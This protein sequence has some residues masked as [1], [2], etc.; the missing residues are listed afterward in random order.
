[1]TTDES[2]TTG[3]DSGEDRLRVEAEPTKEFFVSMLVRDIELLDA[4]IDLLDNSIDGAR[5]L[6]G[7]GALDDLFV[8]V[9]VDEA[10]FSI[11]DNC[12]GIEAEVARRY[13]FRFGR[14]EQRAPEAWSVGQFGVGMKRTLFKLGTGF[15]ITSRSRSSSFQLDVDVDDWLAD[16]EWDFQF[17]TLAE[18]ENNDL[19][20]TG[21]KIEVDRPHE[22]VRSNFVV[23]SWRSR[24]VE[25]IRLKHRMSLEA[26]LL[27]EVNGE[28]V[29]PRSLLLRSDSGFLE[30]FRK[31]LH[32]ERFGVD[33]VLIVGLGESEPIDAGW[34][35]LCNSRLVLGPDRTNATVWQG[36]GR[37]S[38]I[39][40]PN[41]HDQYSRF[42]GLA[43][44][45]A[46]NP[47]HLPW[48]TTKNGVDQDSPVWRSARVEMESATRPLID[49]LN[50]LDKERT[51]ANTD[52]E[53]Q[54]ELADA[55][56]EQAP[57]VAATARAGSTHL[58]LPVVDLS[59]LPRPRVWIRYSRERD[60]VEAAT[61]LMPNDE[62]RAIPPS[63]VGSYAFD[64]FVRNEGGN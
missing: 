55:R 36:G 60:E 30:P 37:Q 50:Q 28:P 47:L 48:T 7:D 61:E 26:G 29:E 10:G 11:E 15:H 57:L 45:S 21:T 43:L 8:R 34:Y 13:A 56:V 5:R 33:V 46:E 53:I 18:G 54:V 27:V 1:M 64:Y 40:I 2:E 62:G 58:V 9:V 63:E 59:A 38:R 42:R 19:A 25:D 52:E 4:I 20:S 41:Y 14:P 49:L 3:G 35:V 51:R 44:F 12:G 6:R 17:T 16:P 39:G 23:S 31:E 22:E 24:L 32:Y